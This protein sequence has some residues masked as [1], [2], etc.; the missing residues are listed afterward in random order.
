VQ[1]VVYE[2]ANPIMLKCLGSPHVYLLDRGEKR[3][4][5][6][7]VTFNDRGYVWRDVHIIPCDDLRSIP[8][9][10]PIPA[11]AGPPPQP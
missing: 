9:G 5:E 7:I 6:N 3:W 2:H 11:D 8:D 4:V 10:A 1:D